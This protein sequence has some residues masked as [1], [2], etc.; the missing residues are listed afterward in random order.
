MT[1]DIDKPS[2]F[3]QSRRSFVAVAAGALAAGV[4]AAWWRSQSQQL[5]PAMTDALWSAEFERPDGSPL[6]LLEFKNRPLVINFWATWC[7]PC[8]E[9]MPL[10]NT[11]FQENAAK[12]WQV[13]GLAIDKPSAVKRFL[14][15][16]PVEYAIG[17]AGLNGTALMTA[18]GNQEGGLPFTLVID[19]QGGLLQR[20]LGKLSDN[21]IR[22]W[23]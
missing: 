3:S 21:D 18:L 15:Q 13:L 10:L 19:S 8:I 12:N 16:H 4:G 14:T 1:Q 17:L 2:N 23:S 6:K 5:P 22:S 9:E 7:T 11:F 20:K